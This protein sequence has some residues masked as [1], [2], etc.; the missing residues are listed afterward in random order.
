MREKSLPKILR[1]E[2]CFSIPVDRYIGYFRKKIHRNGRSR[3][4][5]NVND[6]KRNMTLPSFFSS[7][8][9]LPSSI[10]LL[11][12]TTLLTHSTTFSS[13][14]SSTRNFQSSLRSFLSFFPPSSYQNTTRENKPQKFNQKRKERKIVANQTLFLSVWLWFVSSNREIDQV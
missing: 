13:S 4:K 14:I 8:L 5:H 11:L 9:L 1:S 10:L 2:T 6:L 7:I 3:S 12:S